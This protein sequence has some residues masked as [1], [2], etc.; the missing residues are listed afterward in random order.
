MTV[1]ISY[2]IFSAL[3]GL[4]I[5]SF[6][7][8]L[9][10]RLPRALFA[11]ELADLQD[12]QSDLPEESDNHSFR[13]IFFGRSACP[14]CNQ[15]LPWYRLIPIV[16]YLSS[17][18]RCHNCNEKISLRYPLIEI[19]SM[20]LTVITVWH[21]GITTTTIY[22]LV[23]IW[24]LLT[25]SVIDIEHQLILDILSLPLLWLGLLLSTFNLFTDP[26]M[27]IWGAAAG[28]LILWILFHTFR[29]LTGKEGMGYGD[30]KL[31]AA[32]GAWFGLSA[33]PQIILIASI[34]SLI[35]GLAAVI[36]QRRSMQQA[37][38][39]GPFLALGGGAYLF[40][41]SELLGGFL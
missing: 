3:I 21:F 16:S 27:A 14:K 15:T 10:W 35:I 9:S 36:L 12:K 39:F 24:V 32:L 23:F 34:S 26:V 38:P 11:E 17:T 8:M 29:L 30:F 41:G 2:L 6:I 22:A 1:P 5:G 19:A 25:I 33:I 20:L 28:Y 4:I 18:G 7:S 37:I 31:L 40:L 13:S